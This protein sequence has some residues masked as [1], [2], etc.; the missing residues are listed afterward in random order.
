MDTR[1]CTCDSASVR[2]AAATWFTRVQ[3]Q[4]LSAAEQAEFQAKIRRRGLWAGKNPV[5]PWDWRPR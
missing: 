1:D 4:S 5:P 2:D 3:A